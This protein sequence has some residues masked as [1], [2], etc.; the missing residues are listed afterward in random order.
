MNEV[1]PSPLPRP[2]RTRPGS[3]LQVGYWRCLITVVFAAMLVSVAVRPLRI[4]HDC[5]LYIHCAELFLDGKLPFIDFFDTNIVHLVTYLTA[6][7]VLLGRLVSAPPIPL[8]TLYVIA[9]V[10]CSAVAIWG[11][12]AR[13]EDACAPARSG[14]MLLCYALASCIFLGLRHFGQ[15]D[16]LFILLYLP[17]F[18]YRWNRW[19]GKAVPTAE[20]VL[21]GVAASIGAWTK[22]QYLLVCLAP[23]VYWV[24]ARRKL[25]PCLKPE[26][27]T[28]IVVGALYCLHFFAYPAV[29][30]Q[31]L[32]GYV[33]PLVMRGYAAYNAP[34]AYML[35]KPALVFCIAVAVSGLWL[36]LFRP[37]AVWSAAAPLAVVILAAVAVF[38]LQHKGWT[39]HIIPAVTAAALI[40]GL[41]VSELPSGLPS[42]Q[43]SQWHARLQERRV[44]IRALGLIVLVLSLAWGGWLAVSREQDSEVIRGVIDRYTEPGDPVLFISPSIRP[45][46]PLLTQMNRR[47]ASRYFCAWP[48]PMLY[49]GVE[50]RQDG[51]FPYRALQSAPPDEQRFLR[52]L[53]ED[54]R[55][56][57]PR[58]IIVRNDGV[59][60]ACPEGFVPLEYLHASGFVAV[61]MADYV[62]LGDIGGQR[63][64]LAEFRSQDNGNGRTR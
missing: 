63:V 31:N 11:Q 33:L 16:H 34:L 17:F 18:F 4:N 61:A 6:V 21:L 42:L 53:V 40:V 58:L 64:F 27:V 9:L 5:A 47:Q 56:T 45:I 50:K 43:R 60:Q 36:G 52:E 37:R 10:A 48:M 23:E 57:R 55:K 3:R 51:Q 13:A 44:T 14:P 46:Y 62:S 54:T 22:P 8:F 7:P 20:G 41:L 30:R 38:L 25:R 1:A 15:R 39:Y 49:H 26:T 32:C 24:V 35:G 19:E 59:Y 28:F 12:L 2:N 29:M